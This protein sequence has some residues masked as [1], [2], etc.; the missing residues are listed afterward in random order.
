M[1]RLA[2]AA[3]GAPCVPGQRGRR[4]ARADFPGRALHAARLPDVFRRAELA[5]CQGR[6]R[7]QGGA[8]DPLA[9][10]VSERCRPELPEP[11]PQRRHAQRRR[12]AAHPARQ[13]DR[14]GPDRRDVR[15]RRAQHR[16][17]PARQRTPDRHAAPPARHR[18][19]RAGG[20]A[21]RRRHPGRRS[22]D[23]HG[24]GRRRARRPRDGA[25]HA[26]RGG[27]QPGI[28]DRPLPG[29]L[30]A[31][32]RADT[33]PGAARAGCGRRLRGLAAHRQRARQQPA[34]RHGVDPGRAVHLRHRRVGF[35]QEHAGQRH[36]VCRGGAQALPQP[37]RARGARPARRARR[38]RQGHQ[39]RPKP[40]RAH[41]AQ[42]PGHLHRSVHADPRTVRRDEQ[43]TRAWLRAGPLQLQRGRR[44]LRGL[45]GRRRA[46]SRDA[47]PARRLCA[48][49]RLLWQALQPR[50]ARGALQGQ[51]HHRRV[52]PD[53]GRRERLLQRGTEHR[54]Q[55]ADPA[56]CGPGLH[57]ARPECHHAVGRRGAARQACARAEQ[58][59]H[60]PHAL[61]PG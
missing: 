38:V 36:A 48:V 51:E 34:Q 23:R 53:G 59:R 6:D 24:P 4:P 50:N 31:H 44:P 32:R 15:A 55:A 61:H 45:P 21:R 9:A 56:R 37:H 25:G 58:A 42:Q 28:T 39:R 22:C 11:R 5:G 41:A 29:A 30:A 20:R 47:L 7:R 19:Q 14:L 33:A 8:R 40:D 18:Q 16:A 46:E 57:P 27:S 54:A 2:A 26:G 13:P 52:E 12:I 43:R 10:Q 1:R 3:R 60:R 35:G 49:R 17:A